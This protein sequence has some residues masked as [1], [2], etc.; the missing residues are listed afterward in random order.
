MAGLVP[1]IHV[2]TFNESGRLRRHR[3]RINVGVLKSTRPLTA[4]MPGTSPGMTRMTTIKRRS[5]SAFA[6]KRRRQI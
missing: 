6:R 2:G 5:L 1:A 3:F 4:W